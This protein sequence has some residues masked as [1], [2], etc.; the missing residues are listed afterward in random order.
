MVSYTLG[1]NWFCNNRPPC[2]IRIF[3]C[4]F[5]YDKDNILLTSILK[6]GQW[7]NYIFKCKFD[8]TDSK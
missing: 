2:N 8:F 3:L 5:V 7:D 1:S 4:V 6:G